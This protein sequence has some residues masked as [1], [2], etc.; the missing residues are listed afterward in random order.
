MLRKFIYILTAISLLLYF[1]SS[2]VYALEPSPSEPI[3]EGIDVSNWQGYINY[4]EVKAAGIQIVYIKSS[5]GTNITDPYF[6]INYENAKANGLNIGFYHYVTARSTDEAIRE[7]E[8]FSSVISGT[9]P[10]CKLAMDFESFG[11]LNIT[12]INNISKT[13]LIKVKELTGKDVIIYSDAYNAKN[14]FGE[15][16]ARDYPLWI[17]EYDVSSPTSNV[18]WNNWAGFQYTS[19]GSVSGINGFVDRNKFTQEIFLDSS[20]SINTPKNTT[21]QIITYTVQRGNTLSEIALEYGTTVLE[22]AGLN[23][24]RNPNLIFTGEVLEIDATRSYEEIVSDTG[25]MNH[26]IYTIKRGDTLTSIAKRF[27]VSIESIAILN[28]IQNI[29]LIYAGDRL[30]ISA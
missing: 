13:F 1:I 12:E 22:I 17:A 9:T 4:S 14:T 6:R 25:D 27:G 19:H 23:R 20:E 3:Y 8:Y 16:L 11:N 26:I 24:I 2:C 30:R 29:N 5:Q 7:A 10:N 15:E 18:N 21:N 28:N